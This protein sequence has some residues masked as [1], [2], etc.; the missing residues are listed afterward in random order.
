MSGSIE[1]R[2]IS[3]R[4]AEHLRELRLLTMADAPYAFSSSYDR[5]RDRPDGFWQRLGNQSDEGV[6]GV[7]LVAVDEDRW[8]GLAGVFLDDADNSCGYV[9]GM[10]VAEDRR[11][12]G[13]GRML[14]AA[15]REWGVTRQLTRLRLSVSDSER[16]D[17]ARRLYESVGFVPTGEVEPMASNP[18]LRAHVMTLALG[19]DDS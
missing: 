1:I 12:A 18:A 17:P 4:D 15:I 2:R 10:W 7:T 19:G 9:W 3:A 5:E 8:I 13:I 6:S 16:S 14:I 11:R